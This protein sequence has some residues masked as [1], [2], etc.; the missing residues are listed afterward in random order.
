MTNL[1]I[2]GAL[3]KIVYSCYSHISREG[4]NFIPNHS[5][6]YI[7]SGEQEIYTNGKS[8]IFREGDFRFV[9][10]NQLAKFIKRPAPGGE[11][12]TLSVV[13]DEGTLRDLAGQHNLQPIG[14]YTGDNL[15]HLP[16]G[17]LLTNYLQSLTPY[18]EGAATSENNKIL[19]GLKVR[20]I[21]MIL[22][23]IHPALKNVLFDFSQPGKID[24]AAYMNEH[25]KYNVD[26]N[27]F[28]YMT[29][30]SLATFKRDFEKVFHT[31]PNR[32][33][34]QK[35][36]DDAWYLLKEKGWKSTDVYLEV[37][38]KDYSHFSFAFKKNFGIA[39]SLV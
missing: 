14:P 4:E 19:T 29:G 16:S 26:L 11:F 25:Y 9:R 28:A 13:I 10:K 39:P 24:L 23:D 18:I 34:Q 15:L 8:Y 21:V 17:P 5:F 38:F 2:T 33:I 3:P 32:W 20:E 22:L 37:G 12:K 7:F 27:R 6:S 30:R 35:R 31:T 1:K 36:L